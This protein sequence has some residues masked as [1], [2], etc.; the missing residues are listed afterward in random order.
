MMSRKEYI[1]LCNVIAD[2]L[3]G[4]SFMDHLTKFLGTNNPRFDKAKFEAFITFLV[5]TKKKE[6]RDEVAF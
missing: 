1:G 2:T 4:G 5:D 3:V 6:A